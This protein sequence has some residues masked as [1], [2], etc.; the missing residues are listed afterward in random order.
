M[1]FV[2]IEDN[3]SDAT[4]LSHLIHSWASIHALNHHIEIYSS[5]ADFFKSKCSYENISAFFID[6]ELS[7]MIGINVAKK[8]RKDGF[9]RDIIFITAYN[10]YVF[11][12]YSVHALN[13]LL[14]P[15]NIYNVSNCLNEIYMKLKNDHYTY[16]FH[17]GIV[18][19][20]YIDIVCFESDLHNINIITLSKTYTEHKTL[21]EVKTEV[22]N[23]FVQIHRSY[24]INMSHILMISGKNVQMSNKNSYSIGRRYSN[25]LYEKFI[26]YYT[27]P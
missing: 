27:V 3:I 23:F 5:G 19:I 2:I 8:I 24:I 4:H 1:T 11:E 20:P 9:L 18:S 26:K 15:A 10:E 14:K 6:I 7:D 12:G 21:K 17:S 25:V 13:Y 16:K 22:P